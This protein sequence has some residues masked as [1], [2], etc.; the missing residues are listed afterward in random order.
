[1]EGYRFYSIEATF[2]GET[3][4]MLVTIAKSEE[5]AK[6]QFEER[7]EEKINEISM[8]MNHGMCDYSFMEEHKN[9]DSDEEGDLIIEYWSKD[10]I[11]KS[12]KYD[13]KEFIND[14]KIDSFDINQ[15]MFISGYS[16]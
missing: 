1:M 3:P 13:W 6:K 11:H 8:C 14:V 7:N 4:I 12:I 16:G 2:C 15:M 5:D 9:D 10:S